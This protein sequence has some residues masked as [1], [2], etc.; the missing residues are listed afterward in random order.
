MIQTLEYLGVRIGLGVIGALPRSV[1]VRLGWWAGRSFAGVPTARRRMVE[2][3]ARRLG[4]GEPAMAAHVRDVFGYYGR[5]WAEVFWTRPRRRPQIEATTRAVG[6]V[7][8]R[9]AVAEGRGMVFAVPHVGNWEYAG[10]VASDLGFDLVAVAENLANRR[11][12][13][14]F[15]GLRNSMDIEIVLTGR[16]TIRRL[17]E[18]VSNGKSVALLCDRDL[19][20]RGVPVDF[21]GEQTTIPPGPVRLA[22]ATGAPLFPVA[23]YFDGIG[24]EVVVRDP[25]RLDDLA[26]D[27]ALAVGSQRLANA[28]EQL[29]RRAPAQW[30]L[31]QPNWPSDRVDVAPSL[32]TSG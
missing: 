22:L 14:W 26:E 6:L 24:H 32:A 21:F 12:R 31:L 27:E 25:V 28:L 18:A 4:I 5:Y 19:R 9:E 1:A 30:H 13:D 29:I 2:R 11:I 17:E 23:V 16:S 10:P 7:P 15:V 3:H 8:V 20:G